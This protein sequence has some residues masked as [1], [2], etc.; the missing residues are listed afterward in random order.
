MAELNMQRSLTML[1]E[2]AQAHVNRLVAAIG[3]RRPDANL[4]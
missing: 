2:E 4:N 3:E 1:V